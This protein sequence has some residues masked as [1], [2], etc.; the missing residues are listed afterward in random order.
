MS[1]L[2]CSK[3][4]EYKKEGKTKSGVT[5]IYF[6]KG[7]S[8]KKN[9]IYK[10]IDFNL[11]EEEE[12][13]IPKGYKKRASRK[14]SDSYVQ[15]Y[16]CD[17]SKERLLKNNQLY[18]KIKEQHAGDTT[19]F[20][21]ENGGRP[22]LVYLGPN[23]VSVY[24]TSDQHYIREDEHDWEN[25]DNN[26]WMYIQLISNYKPAITFLGTS[27][28]TEMTEFS[29]GHGEK[30]D[31]NTFLLYIDQNNYV[32]IGYEIYEFKADDIISEYYSPVGNNDVPYP[33]AI[34]EENV[35]FM[36]DRQYIPIDKF[37]VFDIDV[38][39]DAYSYFYG[40]SGNNLGRYSQKMK[41]TNKIYPNV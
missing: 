16:V 30:F 27:S 20:T 24:K 33:V 29:G 22:F 13:K 19:Y 39:L 10:F 35:Y 6:M 38:K 7:L 5:P 21:H 9:H 37:D 32:F 14:S 2:D 18:E 11:F 26:K 40:H 15:K 17:T 31:G 8:G 36:L 41:S 1:K 3:V 28:L 34:G 25:V 23:G 4:V 12:T